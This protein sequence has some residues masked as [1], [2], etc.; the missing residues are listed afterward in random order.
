MLELRHYGD[1]NG[2][3]VKDAEISGNHGGAGKPSGKYVLWTSPL[4]SKHSW[5]RWT[6]REDAKSYIENRPVW[7]I[8]L[9]D[10]VSIYK[11][12]S[13]SDLAR[14][15][16]EC[17]GFN[18]LGSGWPA[19]YPDWAEVFKRY[20]AI[21]L[22]EEGEYSTRL[23]GWDGD[24]PYTLYGWDCETVLIMRSRA[25]ANVVREGGEFNGTC[26]SDSEGAGRGRGDQAS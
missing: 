15:I 26:S 21:W 14:L 13:Y 8:T 20:D 7:R 12:D 23:T 22:T 9:A 16:V 4:H 11:I 5:E 2:G 3:I 6:Q 18:P 17:G 24:S 25:V 19:K 1:L 10:D